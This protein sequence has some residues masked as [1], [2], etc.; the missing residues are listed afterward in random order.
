M[1]DRKQTIVF[2]A[3]KVV[4]EPTKISFKTR[5]GK[6]VSFK[7]VKAVEKPIN[8]KFKAKIK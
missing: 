7:A 2:K 6:N 3:V 8:V 5:D 4:N 1:S